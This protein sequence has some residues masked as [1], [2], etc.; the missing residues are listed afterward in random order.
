MKAWPVH[1]AERV[2]PE[3]K[4]VEFDMS[5]DE[6]LTALAE[7]VR[8]ACLRAAA[9]AHERAAISGLCGEGAWGAAIGAIQMLDLAPLVDTAAEEGR[10]SDDG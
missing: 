3:F 9:E 7:R 4:N 6:R 2:G 10:P 1:R 5:R 8:A